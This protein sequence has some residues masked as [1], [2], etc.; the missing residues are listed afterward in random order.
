MHHKT[1]ESAVKKYGPVHAEDPAR[2]EKQMQADGLDQEDIKEI[3]DAISK[4]EGENDIPQK[5]LRQ[6]VTKGT[7]HPS[8]RLYDLWEVR[9]MYSNRQLQPPEKIKIKRSGVKLSPEDAEDLNDQWANSKQYYY[10][11]EQQ[12]A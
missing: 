9:T 6:D 4:V 7:V 5:L 10:P 2:A 8:M 11:S 3:I 12:P 1:K